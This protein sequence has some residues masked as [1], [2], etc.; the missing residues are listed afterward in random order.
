MFTTTFRLFA[1]IFIVGAV[2]ACDPVV[3][4]GI[5]IDIGVDLGADGKP[6]V[7]VTGNAKIL[8]GTT[9]VDVEVQVPTEPTETTA[10]PEEVSK[11]Q[12][13]PHSHDHFEEGE[14]HFFEAENIHYAFGDGTVRDM[15]VDHTIMAKLATIAGKLGDEVGIVAVSGG[16]P[17]KGTVGKRT[18]STRHDVDEHGY[19]QAVDIYL[20]RDGKRIRPANDMALYA[21]LIELAA[22]HFPG[23]GHYAWGVHIGY[24]SAVFWGPTTKSASADPMLHAAYLRGRANR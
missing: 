7:T 14:I 1:A 22:A 21:E 4:E 13:A 15:P 17:A 9:A 6:N 3:F 20:T 5:G 24:G 18:G 23:I 12:F 10:K 11:S 8:S 16:Q 2:A 19:G